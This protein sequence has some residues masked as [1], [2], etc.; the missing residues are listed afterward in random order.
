MRAGVAD[1]RRQLGEDMARLAERTDHP[2]LGEER[3]VFRPD[4]LDE[5]GDAAFLQGRDEFG[6][7]AS[8]GR[9]E[10]LELRQ[11]D[12]HDIGLV[13]VGAMMVGE[14]FEQALGGTEEQ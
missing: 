12:Q 11:P 9:I 14:L 10:Q 1:R 7:G 4:S 8:P 5:H 6:E 2:E 13:M 3:E